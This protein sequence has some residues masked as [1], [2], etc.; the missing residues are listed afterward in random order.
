MKNQNIGKRLGVAFGFLILVLIG[1]GWLG[2]S[3]M[4]QINADLDQIVNNRWAKVQLTREAL[5][6][7]NLNNRI[8][9]QTF[10]LRDKAETLQLLARRAENSDKISEVVKKL[11]VSAESQE[12]RDLLLAIK[13]Q[14]T[15]YVESYRQAL[16]LLID[17]Q[18][19]DEARVKMV[20]ETIPMLGAY[21]DAW[22]AFVKS[23]GDQLNQAV[24]DSAVNHAK[25]RR[26]ALLLVL[27]AVGTAVAISLFV[28]RSMVR[29]VAKLAEAEEALQRVLVGAQ[30]SEQ[31]YRHLADAMPQMVWTAEPDGLLDYYNQQWFDYTGMTLE[32]TA[33]WGWKPVLH[34]DDLNQCVEIWTN[35]VATGDDY[36]VKYRMRR[37]SD[38]V[39]RWHLGRASAVRDGE[40]Q[41]V[42]WYGTCTDIDDQQ[43][44]EDALLLSREELEDRVNARTAELA[45][46]NDELVLEIVER[47]QIEAEREV[48]FEITQG[49]SA[50]ANLDELLHL[51]HRAISKVLYAE[52]CFVALRDE[53]AGILTMQF[54]LD[55]HDEMPPPRILRRSRTAYVLRTGQP[56]LMTDEAFDQLVSQGEVE[57]IG[58][59]PAAWLGVPLSTPEAVIGVLVLQHYS[60]KDA[61]SDRNL[62]FLTSVGRQIALVIERKRAEESFRQERVFLR[63]L[64]DNIP[65]LV[66]AKDMACRK[67]I[68]NLAEV[69]YLG[70]KSEAEVLGKDD[71]AFY[72]KEIAEGFFADDQRVLQ[73]DQPVL[74][75]EEY[76]IDAQGVQN[77]FLTSK[78]PLHDENGQVTGLIGL[79]RDITERKRSEQ[80]MEH[81]RR[82]NELLLNSVGEGILGLD[83]QGHITFINPAGFRILGWEGGELI[84]RGL[85]SAIHHTKLD[86]TTFGID[87]CL[88][89]ATFNDGSARHVTNEVFWKKDGTSFPVDYT[90]TPIREDE[91]LRGAVVTFRDITDR[92]LAEEAIRESEAKFKD[93]FDHAPVA[94]HELDREGRIIKVNMTELRMLGYTAEEMQGRHAADFIVEK[95]SRE[96]I[97]AK[98]SGKAPLQPVERTFIRKDST[99]VP[100]MIHDQLIYDNTGYVIGLRSTLHDITERKQLEA[101]LELARDAALESVRLKSEFLA[102]M[103]HEIRTP[104]NGV[105]GMTGLLLETE[106]DADQRDFAETIRSSGDA[107]LTLINDILDFSK[108]EAGKLQFETVDFDLRYAVEGT[109]ELLAERARVKHLE[110]AS[111]IYNDVPTLLR[112]DPGRLRQVLMNLIGNALKFTDKGEVIVR[113]EKEAESESAVTIRFS[114]SDTG[115]GIDE[116]AQRRLF[117]AFVQADGSTT[118]KYGGTGLGLSISKQL[119]EMMGGK[120]GLTSVIGAGSTFWFT[121]ELEKQSAVTVPALPLVESLDRLRVL[122]VDDNAT[123]RK[124]LSHQ[125]SSWGMIHDEA[126]SG[127]RGLELL[128]NAAELGVGYDL[129]VLDLLMPG[130][131]GFSLARRIKADPAISGVHLVLLTSSGERGDGVT[132]RTMGIA[133]YL[134]KPIRQSQ[135]FDCLTTVISNA[136]APAEPAPSKLITVHTLQEAKR[137]HNKLILLAEDNIV[138]QKVAIRQLQKLG[139]RADAVANGREALEAL[140]RIPYDLVLMDCQMPEMDGYEAT[141]EIRRREGVTKHTPIVAMTAHALAGD[142]ERSVAAGMDDHITKPVKQEELGKVLAHFFP[143][144][145]HGVPV[146]AGPP[147]DLERLHEAMGSVPEELHEILE[148]YL[149]QMSESLARLDIA[150]QSGNASEVNQIAHNCGGTSANCGMVAVVESFRK[151]E[152]MGS[153]NQL[154]GAA[155]LTAQVGREFAQVKR[156][157]MENLE[158][159]T[160]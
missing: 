81:L 87:E 47:E 28:T 93:L 57:S 50:T 76:A 1:V 75:K 30:A 2:L 20:S 56:I 115:I 86:G 89:H 51:T 26:L 21:H 31:R 35:A 117:Q 62:E 66:Y 121:T 159:V 158:A 141:A 137:V 148:V 100:L 147:V 138:N 49:M 108:I 13:Q 90:S 132:A 146:A 34:P 124:I 18:K 4:G 37:S 45:T 58:T 70:L 109:V 55:Q 131:D 46:A 23:Q 53:K 38:G 7:S 160:V 83:L 102:N 11:E 91:E 48:L 61:Y 125:L 84:G 118:R 25:A 107:L 143:D 8:T 43:R 96:A 65:D 3:R 119:V 92:K 140:S 85:H 135:L 79:G 157:L 40:G 101:D 88:I 123:N 133:A 95:A 99:H 78:I 103:S 41:I 150:V 72:P 144:K 106:L 6:Y 17:E 122:V 127:A 44:A 97:A 151:L 16:G 156:F 110:F 145:D 94:Y 27:L 113:A 155:S 152:R 128:R 64:I 33:G 14:R 154:A 71:F 59:P 80:R 12:E 73:T 149:D 98:I 52:N 39:Y 74:E 126:E 139:Y 60:D 15:P 111:L 54:F 42:K 32:Q 130:M 112:G 24:T 153:E 120:I 67:V 142:R 134:T 68:S 9:M 136:T 82:Q 104:M 116:A 10:L 22:N 77:W 19:F 63:T 129:A 36:E 29:Y 114:V 69:R 5:N 105:I